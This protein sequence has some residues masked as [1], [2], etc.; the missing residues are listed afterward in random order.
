MKVEAAARKTPM[1]GG[2]HMAC[3][4]ST[5]ASP[6]PSTAEPASGLDHPYDQ[7]QEL[8]RPVWLPTLVCAVGSRQQRLDG[9][10][11]WL[12]A[13]VGGAL[14]PLD[15]DFGDPQAVLPLRQVVSELQLPALARGVP[16]LAE[17]VLRTLLWHLDR[18]ND[19][20][21]RLN[22]AAAINQI[23]EEFRAAWRQDTGG[24]ADDWQLLRELTA[25]DQLQ[26]GELTGQ[27]RSRPWAEARRA[28][29]RLQQ[30]PELAAL[31]QRLGRSQP[32]PSTPPRRT[33]LPHTGAT[34]QPLRALETRLAGAPGEL[35]GVHFGAGLEHMLPAE[36]ALLRHPVGRRL[37]RAR[38]AEGR[39]LAYD[40]E[41]VLV[42]WRPDP[43]AP[44]QAAAEA[45]QT[46]PF[47]QGPMVL[48]LDTSGSMRGA[49][50]LIAKAVV[51]AAVRAAQASGRACRLVAF[52]GPGEMV[53][54][55]LT[56]PGGLQSILELMGQAFDGGTDIQTPIEAAIE[57][58]HEAA[59]CSADLLIVS[60][61]EFG[62]VNSTLQRL[63][64]ARSQ[65]GL[66][67]HGV[68]VGDR[69][70]LGMLEVCD[71]IHWVRDWRRHGEE[72]G[73]ALRQESRLAQPVHSK[74][75]TALYF[76]GA[77]SARAARHH[78]SIQPGATARAGLAANHVA[79]RG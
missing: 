6:A 5:T 64:D 47:A 44:Q 4:T 79:P 3:E 50:E 58:V 27:L 65:L 66:A 23:T 33:P 32:R 19:L 28:A 53:Q 36:A 31:L 14:P 72:Q 68:L 51:L 37:W 41:A 24:T 18:L 7:L 43:A 48:C 39:L 30:L 20:Q 15:A 75:L 42:D 69:E 76:P 9:G 55:D 60:D 54:R 34:R 73:G 59:W 70:T 29:D 11:A 52:G 62:C 8:P 77:L 67:V 49:P 35:T 45:P 57:T 38:H 71:H 17:Q 40:T 56:G 74:S 63:D 26:W 78:D 25:G 2:A 1:K 22:R 12:Q 10:R 13:L 46:Q 21:P 61:G 16:V